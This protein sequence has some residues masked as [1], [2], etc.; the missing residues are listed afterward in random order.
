MAGNA[1]PISKSWI[2]IPLLLLLCLHAFGKEN[3]WFIYLGDKK[4]PPKAPRK[5]ISAAE[6]MPPLPLPATPLRRTERKKP[7]Q[8]D[9]LLGKVIWGE[10]AS[11]TDSSGQTMKIADWNLCPTDI[12]KYLET[13]RKTELYYHWSNINLND[14]HFNPKKL[15]ALVF[16]GVRTLRID[17]ENKKRLREYVL[18]G[19]MV[20]CDSVA[21]SPYFYESVKKVFKDVFPQSR[22]RR[23]PLDHPLYHMYFDVEQISIPRDS[24]LKQPVLEGIYIGSRVGVLLSKYGLGCGWN[25]NLAGVKSLGKAVFY[26]V[27][28][29]NKLGINLALYIIGYSEV[30]I[31]EGKPEVFALA[32]QKIPTDEFIFAQI[33]HEGAW[34]VHPGSATNLLMKLRKHTSV[35]VNLKRVAVDPETD[36]ISGYPF[37]YLTGLDDF[38]FNAREVAALQRYLHYGGVLLINNGLGLS[39]FDQAVLREMNKVLG[40][41][42][43]QRLQPTHALFNNL[44]P[45][46][47]VRYTPTVAGK[48]PSQ[49]PTQPVLLGITIGADLRVIYSPYDL[50][51]GWL[52]VYYP[53]MKGYQSLSAQQLGMNIITYVMTH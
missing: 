25:R 32:D 5:S 30:G 12:Q 7:P 17:A 8:P 11:Y 21:G 14:F 42:K 16:S 38:R 39:R 35:R 6:A 41:A 2:Y 48:D 53:M 44:F 49:P 34:N 20:I 23:L 1:N 10:A 19:G 28:S 4:T 36:D 24:K 27:Q 47:Q 29:A 13:I 18:N 46:Q 40:Q 37:L 50:E 52:D 33:K 22:F 3:D 45:I 51:G 26:D 15:P 43:F 31:I 9:Y